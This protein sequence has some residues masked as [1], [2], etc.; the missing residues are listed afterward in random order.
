MTAIS[1][2]WADDARLDEAWGRLDWGE[3]TWD[4]HTDRSRPLRRSLAEVIRDWIV[5]G[6][7]V[8]SHRRMGG[9]WT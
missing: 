2:A 3:P 9:G 4:W 6:H 7:Q 8:R 5:A 1:D